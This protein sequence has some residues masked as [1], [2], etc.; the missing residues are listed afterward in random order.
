[1]SYF[2]DTI[3]VTWNSYDLE[4]REDEEFLVGE[5]IIFCLKFKNH[6][7]LAKLNL[8]ISMLLLILYVFNIKYLTFV[9]HKINSIT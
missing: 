5:Y 3:T 8:V 6:I 1:M 9:E 4:K 2:Y 7:F